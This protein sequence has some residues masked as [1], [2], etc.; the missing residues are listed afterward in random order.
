MKM[1]NRISKAKKQDIMDEYKEKLKA[2]TSLEIQI[3]FDKVC[4]RLNPK[5]A[6]WI[7]PDQRTKIN[8]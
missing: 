2:M 3:E 6:L 7:P 4:R 5:R 8:V 1:K